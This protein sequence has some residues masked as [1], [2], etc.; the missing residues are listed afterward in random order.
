MDSEGIQPVGAPV[1]SIPAPP[2]IPPP[3]LQD[4]Y[5]RSVPPCEPETGVSASFWELLSSRLDASDR[6]EGSSSHLLLPP[7]LRTSALPSSVMFLAR[8]ALL[9]FSCWLAPHFFC[10]LPQVCAQKPGSSRVSS[11]SFSGN[12]CVVFL[13]FHFST[14]SVEADRETNPRTFFFRLSHNKCSQIQAADVQSW[15]WRSRGPEPQRSRSPESFWISEAPEPQSS[16]APQD[17]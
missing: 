17:F 7:D 1:S 14:E 13:F 3:A 9:T 16:K 4:G 12:V 2:R 6:V 10:Y 5:R 8:A 15:I 11:P